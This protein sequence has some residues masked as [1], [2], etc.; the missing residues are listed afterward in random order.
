MSS[1]DSSPSLV[2]IKRPSVSRSSRPTGNTRGS[3]GTR[4]TTV[5][6]PWGSEAVVTTPA[7]LVEQVVHQPLGGGH[8]DAVD[9]DAHGGRVD[10]LPEDGHLAVDRDPAVGH[11]VVADPPAPEA[12]PGQHLLEALGRR[13]PQSPSPTAPAAGRS[14]SSSSRA[15]SV[16][17]RKSSTAGSWSTRSS[18]SRSKNRSVVP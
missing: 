4:E 16:P 11:Q 17:G 14:P 13:P 3:A 1:W 2:R 7:G 8:R 9:G 12:G 5:G 6:R 15:T 18:P 10:P